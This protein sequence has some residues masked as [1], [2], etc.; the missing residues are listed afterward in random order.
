MIMC[1]PCQRP[2]PFWAL[3]SGQLSQSLHDDA[4]APSLTLSIATCW[5]R[6]LCLT[7]NLSPFFP[8]SDPE[9]AEGITSL[10]PEESAFTSS[11]RRVGFVVYCLPRTDMNT[12]LRTVIYFKR[13]SPPFPRRL[14]MTVSG[15]QVAH[16]TC[17]GQGGI[18]R[19]KVDSSSQC[20][21]VF[22]VICS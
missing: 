5:A 20:C 18:W 14:T 4:Y 16:I 2:I 3:R 12:E 17:S 9:L 10:T 15:E 1:P 21:R 19:G 13:L 8:A 6:S 11:T 22:N 7:Q